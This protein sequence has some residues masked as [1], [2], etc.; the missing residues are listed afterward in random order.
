MEDLDLIDKEKTN[1]I[2]NLGLI[3]EVLEEGDNN[4]NN[5]ENQTE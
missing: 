5:N 3:T 2:R 4:E 1:K